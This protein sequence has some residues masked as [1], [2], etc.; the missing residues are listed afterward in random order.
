MWKDG[1]KGRKAMRSVLFMGSFNNVIVA[2]KGQAV[3]SFESLL[4]GITYRDESDEQTGHR[5]KVVIETKDKNQSFH[6][7]LLKAKENI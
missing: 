1:Q 5:E 4:D 2:K 6:Q 7:S 3:Q